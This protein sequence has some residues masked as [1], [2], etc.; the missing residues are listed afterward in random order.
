MENISRYDP[1]CAFTMF[2]TIIEKGNLASSKNLE[3][4]QVNSFL[5]F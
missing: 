1:K 3:N 5:G 4:K 2:Q